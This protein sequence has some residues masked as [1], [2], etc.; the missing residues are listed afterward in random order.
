MEDGGFTV[1][2]HFASFS[3]WLYLIY[4]E[5]HSLSCFHIDFYILFLSLRELSEKKLI[6]KNCL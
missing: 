1:I 6:D 2:K 5:L 4:G 3:D